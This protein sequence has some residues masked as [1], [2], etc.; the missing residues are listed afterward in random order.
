MLRVDGVRRTEILDT[1]ARLFASSG[2]RTSLKEIAD[3]CGILAGSLYHHFA[4]KDAIVVELIERF[5]AELDAIAAQAQTDLGDTEASFASLMGSLASSIADCA[6]RNR[7]ALLF[8][9]FEPPSGSSADLIAIAGRSSGA[10]EKAM[11]EMLELGATQHAIRPRVDL[12]VFADRLCAVL[13][14]ISLGVFQNVPGGDTIPAIRLHALLEG[15][16]TKT[17]SDT[18]LDRSAPYR[19]ANATIAEWASTAE[20]QESG[21]ALLHAA[22]R[23]EFGKR[24]YEATTVRDIAAAAGLSVGTVYRLVGS[25]DELLSSI[26]R[27]FEDTAQDA[28]LAV[29]KADGSVV[30]KLDAL[31]WVNIN[32]VDRFRDEFNIRIA[33]LRESPPDTTDLGES[34]GARLHDLNELLAQGARNGDLVI[35]GPTADIRGWA[36][37][38]LLWMR[39]DLVAALG[40]RASHLLG[41]NTLLRGG[42]PSTKH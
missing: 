15:I 28:W 21:L 25:K 4:S 9:L 18:A 34:F 23:A 30:E 3:E 31:M 19:V 33:W 5:H 13:L 32:L 36:I 29:L 7:A 38:E 14:H 6:V 1:A 40:L 16:A 22:A 17:P 42:A 24:G 37:F 8:D 11:R 41:R 2:F 35:D 20:N 26:M 27:G 39:D 12:A 10:I